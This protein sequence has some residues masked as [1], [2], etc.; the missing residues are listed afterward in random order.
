MWIFRFA[1]QAASLQIAAPDTSYFRLVSG[2]LESRL[3]D[4]PRYPLGRELQPWRP[5]PRACS[6]WR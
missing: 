3:R 6:A 5:Q 2:L 4:K 1:R